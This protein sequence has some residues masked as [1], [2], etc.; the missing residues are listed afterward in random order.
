MIPEVSTSSD[1]N[2]T[3]LPVKD[4]FR[5]LFS[6]SQDLNKSVALWRLPESD[7]VHLV[8]DLSGDISRIKADIEKSDPGFIVSPFI[9]PDN[10]ESIFIKAHVFYSSE[11]HSLSFADHAPQTE[12]RNFIASVKETFAGSEQKILV[13]NAEAS[14]TTHQDKDKFGAIISRA[15]TKIREGKFKK[16]VLAREKKI[17]SPAPI[18]PVDLFFKLSENYSNAFISLIS[19]PGIG[20]WIGASPELLLSVHKD[21]IFRTSSLAGTQSYQEGLKLSDCV[22]TQKEIEEQ[23]LVSRYII[24][25]FKAIRLREY[26]DEGPRTV[27]AGNLLHLRTDFLADMTKLGFPQLGSQMLDLLHPTS[28]V[29]GMPKE[30][31]MKFILEEEKF[32]RSIFTGF[33][34][35][36]NINSES[37]IFVNLRCARLFHQ[38]AI[39]YAGAGITQDSDPEKEWHETEMKMRTIGDFIK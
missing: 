28:A 21:K 22:W 18:N 39:L 24:N 9:N 30:E 14:E 6:A 29:C 19:V 33:L 3:G 23:A 5:A 8:T 25:C 7:R 31:A 17:T 15:L 27:R 26:E 34:G 20:M 11:N 2:I 10:R 37:C 4:V 1:L 32:D 12:K 35:P 38:S 13:S 36:V 16:V